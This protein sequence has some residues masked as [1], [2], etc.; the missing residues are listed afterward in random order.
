[1]HALRNLKRIF[2]IGIIGIFLA[3]CLTN[4]EESIVEEDP[5]AA[6]PCESITFS[7]QV[8]SIIETNC[9][10]C[11]GARGQFPNLTTHNDIS[12]NAALVKS[13]TVSRRMPQG[14]ATLTNDEIA[15]ISC[16][17]DAGALNN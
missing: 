4:V 17:V 10:Q 8:K 7:T 11:H 15:A 12:A 5:T 1:M 13:V 9:V 14:S 6:D 16:W 2:F 3:S